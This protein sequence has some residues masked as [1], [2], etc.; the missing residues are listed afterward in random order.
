[1]KTQVATA[2]TQTELSSL[3]S[4]TIPMSAYDAVVKKWDEEKMKVKDITTLYEQS[5]VETAEA[6]QAESWARGALN[7]SVQLIQALQAKVEAAGSECTNSP[8][9]T[10]CRYHLGRLLSISRSAEA[11]SLEMVDEEQRRRFLLEEELQQLRLAEERKMAVSSPPTSPE[12][13]EEDDSC[14]VSGSETTEN[15]VEFILE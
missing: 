15:S 1:M 6:N 3:N 5:K 12:T 13:R 2:G 11:V 14:S 7:N 4:R 9:C 10:S 8:E